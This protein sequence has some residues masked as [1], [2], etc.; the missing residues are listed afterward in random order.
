VEKWLEVLVILAAVFIVVQ[1]CVTAGMFVSI[2]KLS[3]NIERIRTDLE[4]SVRPAL[5]DFRE[6]L[7]ETKYILQNFHST[8]EN[9]ASIS[10]TVKF[11]VERVN[12]VIEETTDRA[13]IQISRA[14]EVVADAIQKMEAT[15]AI[16]QENVLAPIREASAII[17]GVHGGLHFF[18][19]RKRNAVDQV[20]QDE[21][22]FI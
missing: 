3:F 11:Q 21:E 20:H 17:R 18:F 1:V 9:I 16:V 6:V 8:A 19:A 22:L 14:D 13:R 7:G 12:A 15:S 10:E 5:T 2:R 4:N